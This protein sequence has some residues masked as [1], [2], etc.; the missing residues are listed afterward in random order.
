MAINVLLLTDFSAMAE[1]AAKYAVKWL[2]LPVKFYVLHA[3]ES[4]PGEIEAYIRK[5]EAFA[6]NSNHTFYPVTST[7]NLIDAT[8]KVVAEKEIQL[9][10]MGASGK[11]SPQVRGIGNNT[12]NVI[13]KVKCPV[14]TIAGNGCFNPWN[15]LLFPVD[16]SIMLNGGM[17]DIFKKFPMKPAPV[18]DVWEINGNKQEE[19]QKSNFRLELSERLNPWRV[20]FNEI[21]SPGDELSNKFWEK[22]RKGANLVVLAARNL[23]ISDE[24]L[25]QAPDFGD[26]NESRPPVLILHG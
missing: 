1:N 15:T 7:Q 23:R 16:Y 20:N 14:L 3:G 13:R 9:I 25:T 18:F 2:D 12:Y 22:A 24:L 5:L 8:R 6:G 10:V 21:G 11:N 17:L 26:S 4:K 19:L